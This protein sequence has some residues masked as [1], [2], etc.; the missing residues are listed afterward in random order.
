MLLR[1]TKRAGREVAYHAFRVACRRLPSPPFVASE[2]RK[3]LVPLYAGIGNIVLYAPA[4]KAI[5]DRFPG[6]E[7]VATVGNDR[8]NEE[9]LG[10][11]VVDRV[12]E[13]PATATLARRRDDARRLRAERFDLAVNAFHVVYPFQVALTAA[14]RVPWRCGHVTSPGW[15][16][17]YD[18]LYN[19]PAPMERDQYEAERYME[20]AYALGV[21]RG[22]VDTRPFFHVSDAARDRALAALA[23]RGVAPGDAFVAVHAGTSVVMRW[24]QWGLD[25][26]EATILRLARRP[27]L[28]F[29][30]VGAPDERAEQLPAIERLAA[31]LPGRFADLV[32]ATDVPALGAVLGR[33]VTFVGNDS[34]PMQIA[35][36]LGVPVVVPWGPSDLPRNAPL[37][38]RHAVLFKRL[39]C[40]PCY[41][42]PG[43]S[44]VH[45]CGDRQCL[46]QISVD[47]V[48][49][50]ASERLVTLG[51]R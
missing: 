50:A 1:A 34:G 49:G 46:S 47:D 14:A 5:R 11:G 32:G 10:P 25:R 8:R 18:F 51:R 12:V 17:P 24:K 38:D 19:L 40:S 44:K 9:V 48:V 20:L 27:G 21:E 35:A 33:A 36:A 7:I 41:R 29:V 42:M 15:T 43:D 4:L 22:S 6:A 28:K 3:V 13:V 30:L 45:L 26:F 23:E 39:P 37:G 31:A 16:N 2:V